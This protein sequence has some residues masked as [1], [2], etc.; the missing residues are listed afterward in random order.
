MANRII[1]AAVT[2]ET[3]KLSEKSA[4]AAGSFNAVSLAFTFDSAW[5]GTTKKVYFFD[6]YGA[7]AVYIVLTSNLLVDGK[8]IVPIPAEPLAYA[9]EMTITVK[10]ID[11]ATD[12][13]T[14]ERIIMSASTT[15]KV[16]NAITPASDVVPVEP[17]PTQTEQLQ[18]EIDDILA[19]IEAAAQAAGSAT[20]AAA[21][22]LAAQTA[23]TLAE[24]AKTSAELSATNAA[25]YESGANTAK[26]GAESA[27][28]SF[29][30]AKN[31][32]Q[33]AKT[34]AELAETHAKT[35]E[36]NSK[37][38]EMNSKTSETNAGLSALAASGSATDANNSKLA[39]QTAQ[40]N[41]ELAE[42]YAETAEAN[43][44]TAETGAVAA[45]NAA[46]SAR[47][48]SV[49]A[50][51]NAV[52][53]KTA[54]E[55]AQGLAET[56]KSGADTAKSG[57]DTA[58]TGAET[59]R[60]GAESARDTAVTAKDDAVTAKTASQ[61]AQGLAETAES[62]AEL[63]EANAQTAET[64]ATAKAVLSESY[65]KGGTGTRSGEDT[66]NAKWYKEQAGAIV[67]GDY[68]TK[69][70]AFNTDN[71]VSGTTNKVYTATEQTKLSGIA[72]SANNYVHPAEHAI[73]VITGLQTALDG[74][75]DDSQVLTNVPVG[76]VFT[77]TITT[78]NGNTGAIAKADIVA[79]GIPAQ[80]T[81]YSA[82]TTSVAGL[83]S[84]ADKTKLDGIATGATANS[85]DA[86]LLNRANHTGTQTKS[87][88]SDFPTTMTPSSHTHGNITNDGKIG[89]T[90]DLMVCT[91]TAGGV[92]TKTVADTKALLGISA[93]LYEKIRAIS[94][95]SGTTSVS[96][97][98]SD[99][100]WSIWREIRILGTAGIGSANNNLNLRVNLLNTNYAGAVITPGNP[101]VTSPNTA[102][103]YTFTGV[104][105]LAI[106]PAMF[107][108]SILK[109]TISS[110]NMYHFILNRMFSNYVLASGI[111]HQDA[112]LASLNTF[113]LVSESAG[114]TVSLANASLW[115]I[116]K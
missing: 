7:N 35:S 67:G 30:A 65:A 110:N 68:P 113:N 92:T 1:T 18:A 20:A 62:H 14:A 105:T 101:G 103:M 79:L 87:T 86:T 111:S 107:D 29:V 98:V 53:A 69:A 22:A 9:G 77:D 54:S 55:T 100:D 37:T 93:S 70:E 4:G 21:S 59:A 50:K 56:A 88:I 13:T 47:D 73:S 64:N 85:A 61:T 40:T 11:F 39:A 80:D 15:M 71:H 106:A 116:R 114:Q 43:A 74:K 112:A 104:G 58:K 94:N 2:G 24:T 41:A 10:G 17:T 57:A 63:A 28:S 109:S 102:S 78:V 32:A 38:S 3:I 52:L 96:I 72:E 89:S 49:T 82:A 46:E 48:I 76:A 5:D 44:E 90:A 42:T 75:V 34:A 115:G 36:T 25:G 51:D 83:E 26:L 33:T 27:L 19:D 23:K 60:T 66:D 91:T 8:Y 45:K 16:L 99:I 108:V 6:A 97:D 95:T 12:G 31:D 84:A 81:T